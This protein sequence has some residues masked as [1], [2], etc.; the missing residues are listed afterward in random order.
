[1]GNVAGTANA[2]GP[3]HNSSGSYNATT[4]GL[5]T[6]GG[7]WVGGS[8]APFDLAGTTGAYNVVDDPRGVIYNGIQ[9]MWQGPASAVNPQ[10][11]NDLNRGEFLNYPTNTQWIGQ[12][13]IVTNPSAGSYVSLGNDAG[14]I[15]GSGIVSVTIGSTPVN[16]VL[17]SIETARSAE[18]T[19]N[20]VAFTSITNQISNVANSGIN[21]N[22][23]ATV[24]PYDTPEN[25]TI[26]TAYDKSAVLTQKQ[27]GIDA[28]GDVGAGVANAIKSI[29]G[30]NTTGLSWSQSMSALNGFIDSAIDVT[31]S[32]RSKF[33]SQMSQV[34]YITQNLASAS[35]NL[36]ATN[37]ALTD[38]NYAS[39]TADLVKGQISQQAGIQMVKDANN[40]PS[41]LKALMREWGNSS[42]VG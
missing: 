20:G 2:G 7:I 23:I 14:T 31:S 33:G 42:S 41:M 11:V 25:I 34:S 6:N 3:I 16:S 40:F 1:L 18:G 15:N 4:I 5:A 8:P 21:V 12:T 28:M 17:N 35:S 10:Y 9:Q 26:T 27:A 19:M 32:Q 13:G 22:L 38:T 30:S 24:H 37:S 36:T 29:S 39:T